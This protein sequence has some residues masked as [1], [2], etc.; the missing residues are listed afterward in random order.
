MP[1]IL[2]YTRCKLFVILIWK[3]CLI[4][5]IPFASLLGNMLYVNKGLLFTKHSDIAMP[6]M[7]DSCW[8]ITMTAWQYECSKPLVLYYTRY[9]LFVILIWKYCLLNKITFAREYVYVSTQWCANAMNE[10]FISERNNDTFCQ[11]EGKKN[12]EFWNVTRC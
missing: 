6:W 4:N 1:L 7:N 3:Y 11:L 12:D 10:Q 2:Y 5:K 9:K 8:N